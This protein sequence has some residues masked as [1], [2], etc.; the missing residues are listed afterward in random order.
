MMFD[1]KEGITAKILQVGRSLGI[2]L[3]KDKLEAYSLNKGDIVLVFIKK[4]DFVPVSEPV[5]DT[6]P[7]PNQNG[8]Q[9]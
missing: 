8:Q 1:E 6:N 2:T 3:P 9:E 7:K 5:K 4:A